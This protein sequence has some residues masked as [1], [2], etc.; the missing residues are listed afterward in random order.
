MTIVID[1]PFLD[2]QYLYYS[3]D[4]SMVW[5]SI[6]WRDYRLTIK[7]PYYSNDY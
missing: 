4:I 7:Y 1:I 6:L 2:Y 5:I 3:H